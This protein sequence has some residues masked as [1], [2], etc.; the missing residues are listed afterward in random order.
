VTC[1]PRLRRSQHGNLS[2]PLYV[3]RP[4]LLY[5]RPKVCHHNSMIL[6]AACCWI[7]SS[8]ACLQRPNR[9][10]LK[11]RCPMPFA[12]ES[13]LKCA[14]D[15]SYVYVHACAHCCAFCQLLR[16]GLFRAL[17]ACP[18]LVACSKRIRLRH[19]SARCFA[20]HAIIFLCCRLF[21]PRNVLF[22]PISL[23]QNR[24]SQ[25]RLRTTL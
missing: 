3:P 20:I 13:A 1:D 19:P 2:Q 14:R 11:S 24:P 17:L 5:N 4:P 6:L 22:G 23:L 21:E 9:R 25:P 12:A 7:K 16:R 18:K 8:C 15:L 10:H